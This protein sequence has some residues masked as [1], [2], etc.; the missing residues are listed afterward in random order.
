MKTSTTLYQQPL[1]DEQCWQAVCARDASH[2]GQFVFA[3]RTTGIFCRPSCHSR[4]PLRENVGF[5]P[6][7]DTAQA[8]GFRPCKRCQP[9]RADPQQQR[10]AK[11]EKACRL[12]EQEG[13]V[14]LE[15]LADAVAMSPWH[16]HRLF[17]SVT[18][19]TPKAWQLAFRA[20]R[21]R[22]ALNESATIT[23]AVLAAG[24]PDNSSYYRQADAA[25]GM[26]A[27]QYRRGGD[28]TD[29]CYALSHCSLG[30][31]LVAQ[32]ERG[33]CAIL[34]ADNEDAL[35]EELRTIFPGARREQADERFVEQVEEVVRRIDNPASPFTLPLD[36]RGT[37]FQLQVWNALRAIPVGETVS[38]QSLANALGK[39]GAV[40]A[41]ARACAA[42]KLA[43]VVP[44]HRVVRSDGGLSGYRWG[45]T[46][47]A[48]L[49]R[50]ES[51]SKET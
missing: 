32:S 51:E 11:V 5:Y 22:N 26:T 48:R 8:A 23:D 35:L 43:I 42:N 27:R 17:K 47:K 50:Q 16:F 31:C 28:D 14:T 37:A 6:D 13:S 24:F 44:C 39:P 9:E 10:I 25:L 41:V 2:D 33:I 12:L 1:T 38:Y 18:G 20:Q 34:L 19:M 45:A 21:L 40:R 3:V 46:R 4:R 29:V 7:A 36:L 15:T 30:H 49:L